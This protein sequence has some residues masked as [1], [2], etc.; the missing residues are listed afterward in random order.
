MWT[1]RW[2][3][4]PVVRPKTNGRYRSLCTPVHRFN[5]LYTTRDVALMSTRVRQYKS[6]G[7]LDPAVT[8][9]LGL[10]RSISPLPLRCSG[11]PDPGGHPAP[12]LLDL[13]E[14][15]PN[16]PQHLRL[17]TP[18]PISKSVTDVPVPTKASLTVRA[19]LLITL[20]P[21]YNLRTRPNIPKKSLLLQSPWAWESASRYGSGL[22]TPQPKKQSTLSSTFVRLITPWLEGTPLRHLTSTSP[23]KIIG[24]TSARFLPLQHLRAH[25]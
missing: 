12:L 11:L 16:P 9:E 3:K 8:P 10:A 1:L 20:A 14:P 4:P 19:S 2:D 21:T 13:L 24:L 23:K 5:V 7:C 6:S 22:L 18:R 25:P 17:V 15:P